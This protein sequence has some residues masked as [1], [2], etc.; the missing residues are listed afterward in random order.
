MVSWSNYLIHRSRPFRFKTM[1]RDEEPIH[2]D[3]EGKPLR[4]THLS[5]VLF[6][7]DGITK[8]E[9]LR[10]YFNV[11][12]ALLPHIRERPLTLKAF[13]HGIAERPYYRRHLRPSD[14]SWLPRAEI[15]EGPA[16]FIEDVADL[17]W[18]ANQD[19]VE[20]HPWLSRKGDLAHPDQLL[21]D[22]DPGPDLPMARLCE[23]A[24]ILKDMLD[25]MNLESWPKTSGSKGLHV[26]VGI[27]AE[28]EF[29]D[30]RTWVMAVA[31]I[32]AEHRPDLFTAGYGRRD[33]VGRVLVDYNQIGYGRTTASIYSVRP[34]NNA[35]VSAPLTWDEVASS[36]F[37]IDQFNIGSMPDRLAAVGDVA[38]GLLE[39]R[40]ALPLL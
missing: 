18:V 36:N 27:A 7:E 5:K 2:V 17:M 31:R 9:L 16:P 30:V 23:A 21:F 20:L 25:Q 13:P 12:P 15:E 10:Y 40:Q 35:P 37:T 6:P 11:A 39:S 1:K 32:L 28:Y 19:A 38:A 8:A 29:D 14:P 4:V 3:V 34:L 33:R 22:L 26:L 24:M